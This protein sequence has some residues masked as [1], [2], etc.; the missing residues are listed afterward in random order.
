MLGATAL[1]SVPFKA[2][3]DGHTTHMVEMLNKEPDGSERQVFNPPVIKIAE[4]DSVNFVST[5]RGHNSAS[6]ADMLPEGAEEWKGGINDDI[7]VTFTVPGV[8][9][10]FCTPH[11]SAGMVGL[12][13]VGDVTQEQIDAAKEVRQRGKARARYEDYFAMAEEMIG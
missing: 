12:V 2:L 6:N 8:Y 1:A 5:D 11:Q 9:G 7:E 3:A 10:Y 13:L 4:G